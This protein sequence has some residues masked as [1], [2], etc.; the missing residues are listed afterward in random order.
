MI[1]L[2]TPQALFLLA[3]YAIGIELGLSLRSSAGA[4]GA[5][6]P[7]FAPSLNFSDKRNSMYVPNR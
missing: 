6:P 1:H 7:A 2:L 3:V 5:A 4:G